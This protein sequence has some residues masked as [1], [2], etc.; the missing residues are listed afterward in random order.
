MDRVIELDSPYEGVQLSYEISPD[1]GM[2]HCG[3]SCERA[4]N[5]RVCQNGHITVL[6][7]DAVYR[8]N[9]DERISIRGVYGVPVDP[10]EISRQLTTRPGE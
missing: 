7:V 10:I 5:F 3:A 6:L 4:G 2:C 9:A 8:V 1:Q